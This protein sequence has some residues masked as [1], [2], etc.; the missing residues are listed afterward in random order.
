MERPL[1]A[2]YCSG[3][4]GHHDGQFKVPTSTEHI[5]SGKRQTRRHS[6]GDELSAEDKRGQ[7]KVLVAISV[8]VAGGCFLGKDIEAETAMTEVIQ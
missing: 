5:F 8:W 1:L 2:V 3:P 6:A 7:C 4:W